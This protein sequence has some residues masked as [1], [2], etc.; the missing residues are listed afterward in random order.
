MQANKLDI[1]DGVVA[2]ING[3][4]QELRIVGVAFSPEYVFQ[5]KPGDMLPD[6]RNFGILWMEHEALSIAY[7]MEG[8]FNDVAISLSHGVSPEEVIHR[9]DL[10]LEPY[11]GL[12]AE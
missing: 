4:R 9:A 11:G 7:D 2:I 5:I 1:G 6:P 3:R 10:L 8:A 12:G